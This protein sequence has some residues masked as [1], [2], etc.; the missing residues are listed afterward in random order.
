MVK[1]DKMD[2]SRIFSKKNIIYIMLAILCIQILFI[3]W[4]NL[5]KCHDWIDHDA[6]MLYSHTIHMWEQKKLVIPNYQEETFLHLDTSCILAMPLYGITHDIFLA[7][8]ISN[9]IFLILTL[10]IMYGL[11]KRLDVKEEYRYAA[12]I[13]YLIPYRIGLVQYFN[14]LFFECSFYNV[15]IIVTLL[16]LDLYLQNV[17]QKGEKSKKSY[18][19]KLVL[20]VLFTILTAFSRGTYVLL[21]ALL[22]IMLC[23]FLEIILSPEGFRHIHRSKIILTAV[24]FISY[25]IG[26]G[27]G[28]ITGFL[29]NTTGYRLVYP[30]DL[31]ENFVH[32]IWGHLSIFLGLTN[33]D[34]FSPQGIYQ[35]IMIGYALLIVIVL[36]F[37]IKHAFGEG[38]F[39]KPLRYLSIIYLWNVVI[40][41][42]TNCSESIWGFPERYLFPG[43]VPLLLSIPLMLTYME[44][45]K[46]DALRQTAFFAVAALSA[47]T[48]VACNINTILQIRQNLKDVSGI[49]EVIAHAHSEGIDTVFFVNDDNAAL[50]TR[51]L[52]PD[53]RVTSVDKHEDGT[54]SLNARENYRTAHDRGNYGDENILAMTWNEQPED[55]FDDY[56]I[57]S[58]QYIGDVQDYHLYHAGSDKF[59]E[60]T[61]FPIDD[62]HLSK[63]IDFAYSPEYTVIGDID[64]YG[65]LETVG[66]DNYALISPL[67]DAPYTSCTVRLSYEMGHKTAQD[68]QES[69]QKRSV[70]R[71]MLLDENLGE[72]D[73]ADIQSD[74]DSC[75]LTAEAGVPCYVAVWI[76]KDEKITLCDIEFEV[77][78]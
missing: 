37:N 58:Y 54:Y 47:A 61:G 2:K 57:S 33:P 55:V 62:G 17:P 36:I 3:V 60:M 39:A 25:A 40:L 18:C 14:M 28:K 76:N 29:P 7:Y 8:G 63:T 19:V 20:Y 32:V 35:L 48:L 59:D 27:Y 77:I 5:F 26:M 68:Q 1:G 51:S 69:G 23:Y 52:A 49:K 71:F 78:R 50:I 44:K 6:S 53:L 56:M 21:M 65:Y 43:F 38:P 73:S 12:M 45:I 31:F 34:V 24:T 42:M 70:G 9:V 41:G 13:L 64:L 66:T 67:L 74:S 46:R 75:A 16:A 10:W 4:I 11:E 15:C 22:P 30:R 72:I